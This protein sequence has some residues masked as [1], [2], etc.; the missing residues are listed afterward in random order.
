MRHPEIFDP[1]HVGTP[2]NVDYID[3]LTNIS[4]LHVCEKSEIS[5]A[6]AQKEDDSEPQILIEGQTRSKKINGRDVVDVVDIV[7]ELL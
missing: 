4:L 5:Y 2:E 3:S 7:G 1:R 6:A